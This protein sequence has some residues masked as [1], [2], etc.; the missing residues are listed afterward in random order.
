MCSQEGCADPSIP[1]RIC[2]VVLSGG[3]YEE[4][5][6]LHDEEN[7]ISCH[8]RLK[9]GTVC[10]TKQDYFSRK[11]PNEMCRREF[12]TPPNTRG[13]TFKMCMKLSSG[14]WA[15]AY[16]LEAN[17]I[18]PPFE[19]IVWSVNE[20]GDGKARCKYASK[21][22]FD[23]KFDNYVELDKI[24]PSLG[25]LTD[26][27]ER[28]RNA[29][30]QFVPEHTNGAKEKK[31]KVAL[32]GGSGKKKREVEVEDEDEEEENGGKDSRIVGKAK[33][34][35]KVMGRDD[36]TTT[37]SSMSGPSSSH[38]SSS[39]EPKTKEPKKAASKRKSVDENRNFANAKLSPDN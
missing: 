15:T 9:D 17:P 1:C 23:D 26:S 36:D 34:K 35:A 3:R 12:Y 2:E 13:E 30:V 38:G 20:R 29:H 32:N 27:N 28:K 18:H 4:H 16:A 7:N 24:Y 11:C 19:C 37:T 33:T 10:G 39:A 5:A 8:S 22:F 31:T 25:Q 21:Q 14:K 6:A